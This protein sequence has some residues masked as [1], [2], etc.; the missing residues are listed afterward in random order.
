M[1]KGKKRILFDVAGIW[2]NAFLRPSLIRARV[3]EWTGCNKKKKKKKKKKEDE[4][5][6]EK[7]EEKEEKKEKK[8]KEEEKE[9]KKD[10]KKKKKKKEKEKE[11]EKDKKKE[12]KEEEEKEEEKK[13]K[14]R[15]RRMGDVF[16]CITF[17][18]VTVD[19]HCTALKVSRQFPLVLLV[20]GGWKQ[21]RCLGIEEG[22]VLE[23]C[24]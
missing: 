16:K 24:S 17:I 1:R 23:V 15:K 6:E 12:E 10:E 21:S 8:K 11:E 9:E 2:L 20:K 5:K 22:S 13:K 7:E 14:R 18:T 19:K 3:D 4:K